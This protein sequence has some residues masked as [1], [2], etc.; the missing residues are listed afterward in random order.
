MRPRI[1]RNV[2]SR[3]PEASPAVRAGGAPVRHGTPRPMFP[4]RFARGG[5]ITRQPTVIAPPSRATRRDRAETGHR[6]HRDAAPTAARHPRRREAMLQPPTSGASSPSAP[7]TSV[8]GRTHRW[9]PDSAG[10]TRSGAHVFRGAARATP[11]RRAP[12]NRLCPRRHCPPP[13]RP[14][15]AA[16]IRVTAPADQADT[17]PKML[18]GAVMLADRRPTVAVNGTEV[19][20]AMSPPPRPRPRSPC[21]SPF[22]RA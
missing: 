17:A 11:A 20:S 21:R 15:R 19:S 18:I 6:T 4:P 3:A 7:L 9:L 12:G 10:E 1:E 2:R 13:R 16:Q 22:E 5:S 14:C 8:R